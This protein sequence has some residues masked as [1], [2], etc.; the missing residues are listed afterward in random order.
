[1]KHIVTQTNQTKL[2]ETCKMS[3]TNEIKYNGHKIGLNIVQ[4]TPYCS[5]MF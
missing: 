1:M 5:K 3:K 2:D 4:K